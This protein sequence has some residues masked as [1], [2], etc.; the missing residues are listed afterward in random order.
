M[1]RSRKRTWLTRQCGAWLLHHWP[2]LTAA[3]AAFDQLHK[4]WLA[5]GS[6]QR[7]RSDKLWVTTCERWSDLRFWGRERALSGC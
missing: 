2:S 1:A 4:L 3:D 6:S 5:L 7:D